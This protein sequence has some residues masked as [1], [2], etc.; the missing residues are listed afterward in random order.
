MEHM[1]VSVGERTSL[2]ILSTDTNMVTLIDES[3]EGKRLSCSPVDALSSVDSLVASLENLHDLRVEVSIGWQ[4][5]D[6]VSDFA[7]DGKINTGV[8]HLTVALGILD[9]LPLDI[10]PILGVELEILGLLICFL[11]LGKRLVVNV[12]E[13]LLRNALVNELLTVD[14]P[15]WVH[16]LDNCIHQWL[17]E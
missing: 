7:H 13:S 2:D 10:G 14:V 1:R 3:G 16:I 4:N 5:S 11:E 6:L 12:S 9:L 15:H 8:F 17:G